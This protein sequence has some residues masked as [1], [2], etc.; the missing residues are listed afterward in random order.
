MRMSVEKKRER[1]LH[2]LATACG[3]HKQWQE[4]QEKAL[5]QLR[6]MSN[7][8][9]QLAALG[10]CKAAGRLGCLAWYPQLVEL[11]EAKILASFQRALWFAY[12]HK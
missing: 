12:K 2:V 9:E 5:D 8:A 11:L 1:I 6:S 7:L 10:E 3:H 4:V